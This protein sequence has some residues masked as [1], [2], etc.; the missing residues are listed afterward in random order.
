MLKPL[1]SP[2]PFVWP[3]P[4]VNPKPNA[5]PL[6]W[7]CASFCSSPISSSSL[8]WKRKRGI[9]WKRE[10]GREESDMLKGVEQKRKCGRLEHSSTPV[11]SPPFLFFCIFLFQIQEVRGRGAAVEVS[12]PYLS[13]ASDDGFSWTH[14]QVSRCLLNIKKYR[15][16]FLR[17]E[18]VFETM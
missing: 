3:V 7:W 6:I 17:G 9:E 2:Q 12:A 11:S 16:F 4:K 8:G 10:C 18:G 14:G 1:R 15:M 13:S 5:A